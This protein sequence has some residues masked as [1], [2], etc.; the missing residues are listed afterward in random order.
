MPGGKRIGRE[1]VAKNPTRP[2][3]RA[4]SSKVNLQTGRWADFATGDKGGDA[5][6]LAAYLFGLRQSEAARRL[7]DAP[8]HF[9]GHA[10][11]DIAEIEAPF[12]PLRS[13][14]IIPMATSESEGELVVPV[15]ADA[16]AMPQTQRR[17]GRPRKA[18]REHNAS[19]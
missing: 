14:E 17:T 5:V 10:M 16:P 15:P 13:V 18:E 9:R 4:G 1:Y 12:A 7:A 2:D 6:S 19:A 11:N 3:R 8:C